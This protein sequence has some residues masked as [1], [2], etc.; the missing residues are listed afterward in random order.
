MESSGVAGAPVGDWFGLISYVT[1]FQVLTSV[2]FTEKS[3]WTCNP[4]YTKKNLLVDMISEINWVR[5][6]VPE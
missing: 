2:P 5:G 6:P 1:V 3:K 4:S